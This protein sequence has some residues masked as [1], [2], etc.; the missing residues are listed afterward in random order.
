MNSEGNVQERQI[1]AGTELNVAEPRRA[2]SKLVRGIWAAAGVVSFALGAVG[3]VLPILPTTPLILLAAFCFARSSDRL[4]QW[5]KGTKLYKNVFESYVTK[6]E[7]SVKAKL[8]ILIPV[9][10]VMGIGFAFMGRVPVGRA[11]LAIVWLGHVIYFGF[12]VK[13]AP[14]EPR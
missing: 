14:T 11:I 2:R 8:S 4:D 13:T 5:F 7:M 1:K 10:V 9:T 12:I 3:S 6:R